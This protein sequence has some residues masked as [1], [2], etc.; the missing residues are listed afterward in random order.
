MQT[1]QEVQMTRYDQ[2]VDSYSSQPT[3]HPNVWRSILACHIR[4][5][6]KLRRDYTV[7]ERD[8]APDSCARVPFYLRNQTISMFSQGMKTTALVLRCVLC[9]AP[10][11]LT[12]EH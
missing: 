9:R 6:S 3:G 1:K 10:C 2:H 5:T 7:A 12:Q 8:P 11:F 4:H